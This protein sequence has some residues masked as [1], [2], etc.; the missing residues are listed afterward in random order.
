MIIQYLPLYGSGVEVQTITKFKNL[1]KVRAPQT[2]TQVTTHSNTVT[3]NDKYK[4]TPW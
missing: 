1:S 4:C 3:A 2:D